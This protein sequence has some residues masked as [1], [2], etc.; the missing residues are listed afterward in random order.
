MNFPDG[1][2]NIIRKNGI[3]Y[4]ERNGWTFNLSPPDMVKLSLP[5]YVEGVDW[6]VRSLSELKSIDSDM[7]M[8]KYSEETFFGCDASLNRPEKALGGWIYSLEDEFLGVTT[9]R[10]VWTCPQMSL[11]FENAPLKIFISLEA[12]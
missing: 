8:I 11:Y 9:D 2:A 6:F 3:F 1:Q 10:K 5:P 4:L 7:M 12:R